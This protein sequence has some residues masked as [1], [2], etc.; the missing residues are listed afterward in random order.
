MC[1]QH[2]SGKLSKNHLLMD[3][4]KTIC[5]YEAPWSGWTMGHAISCQPCDNI[6]YCSNVS[7]NE[8]H[9][10]CLKCLDVHP[11]NGLPLILTNDGAQCVVAA[12]I[13]EMKLRRIEHDAF[14]I[15]CVVAGSQPI[16]FKWTTNTTTA[17]LQSSEDF[18]IIQRL[19]EHAYVK[20]SAKNEF[21]CQERNVSVGK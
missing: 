15:T 10:F 21:G 5:P 3:G 17:S 11:K 13:L 18:A 4:N 14:R 6:S 12:H 20:C 9:I 19:Q 16:K 1:R 7:C 2:D 8:T